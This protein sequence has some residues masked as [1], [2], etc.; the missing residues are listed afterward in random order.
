[1]P[2]PG[3]RDRSLISIVEIDNP[4]FSADHPEALGNPRR[5]RATVRT[6]AVTSL[7]AHGGLADHHLMAARRLTR[8]LE[9][10]EGGGVRSMDPER[11]RV[12]GG[13][14]NGGIGDRELEAGR[15]LKAARDLL[16]LR[17][18]GLVRAVCLEG[19]AL[20]EVPNFPSDKRTKLFLARL[21]R[22]ALDDMAAQWGL[23]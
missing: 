22:L 18:Y 12:D 10:L 15:E 6:D 19:R 16:G 8:L 1:M 4:H 23:G 7:Y 9:T 5:I 2:P 11:V 20:A 13:R 21:L 3:P 17:Q 14:L